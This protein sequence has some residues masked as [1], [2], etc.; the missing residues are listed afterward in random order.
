MDSQTISLL[1]WEIIGGIAL[2]VFLIFGLPP[3]M[4]YY[5]KLTGEPARATIL[6]IRFGRW[7]AYSGSGSSQSVTAQR[8]ILKLEVHPANAMPYTAEDKFMAKAMD[9]LRLNQGCDLQVRIARHNPK[10][11]VCLPDT[12]TAS[13]SAPLEARGGLAM[14]NLAEQVS[15]GKVAGP[16]Q[17]LDALGAH[18]IFPADLPVTPAD[19]KAKI[20]MLKNM[21]DSGLITQQEFEDKKKDI[22]AR[23]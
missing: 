5:V 17:V 18:G 2:L 11:V 19:P 15:R 21:L 13:S 4:R 1:V 16:Q 8:V 10:R 22:L 3:L 9:L 12:L 6:E 14:A 7:T 20:E 23:M